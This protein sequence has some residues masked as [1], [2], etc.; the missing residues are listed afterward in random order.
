MKSPFLLISLLCWMPLLPAQSL[1][2]ETQP[3]YRVEAQVGGSLLG[4]DA[5][6]DCGVE[7]YEIQRNEM[8]RIS[9]AGWRTMGKHF[10][11]GGAVGYSRNRMAFQYRVFSSGW[12]S[13]VADV[14]LHALTLAP[15][16]RWQR[17]ADRGIFAQAALDMHLSLGE[18]G[19]NRRDGV[20]QKEALPAQGIAQDALQ[21]GPEL[22]L[23]YLLPIGRGQAL[24]LR[25]M[26]G[27]YKRDFVASNGYFYFPTGPWS[28]RPGLCLGWNFGL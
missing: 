27:W 16:I 18:S 23:G 9:A 1:P 7:V 19:W 13:G 11:L 14:R 4:R 6:T 28:I 2:A 21:I 15:A 8:W 25:A 22:S 10:Y 20:V 24:G 5:G 26:A 3:S 17:K 12:S